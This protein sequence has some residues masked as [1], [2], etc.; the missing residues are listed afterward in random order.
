MCNQLKTFWI[1]EKVRDM[2]CIYISRRPSVGSMEQCI[3]LDDVND[4]EQGRI[5]CIVFI[6]S[7]Y[8]VIPRLL[9]T[10]LFKTMINCN[11]F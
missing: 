11:I 10:L 3:S 8:D 9:C 2:K 5:A 4:H 1:F 6:V 7:Y